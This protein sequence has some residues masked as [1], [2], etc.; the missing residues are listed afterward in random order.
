MAFSSLPSFSR[1]I[2]TH[3]A[4]INYADR[5]S[6]RVTDEA[7]AP[8]AG[9]TIQIKGGDKG[10]AS[11]GNGTYSLQVER[12][13]TIVYSI[14]GYKTQEIVYKGQQRIDITMA[15]LSE[16]LEEVVAIGYGTTTKKEVTGSVTTIKA[17]DFNKGTVVNPLGLIQGKVP[18]L[19]IVRSQGS[20]PNGGFQVRLRGIRAR[21][22]VR[23]V[24]LLKLTMPVSINIILLSIIIIRGIAR[25]FWR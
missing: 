19:S 13:Q 18:G 7:G 23:M 16:E 15:T 9:V 25:G 24:A 2:P 4:V 22:A 5:I 14:I 17:A 8:L 1:N 21:G 6:G 20:N 12:G 3:G 10:T 11:D